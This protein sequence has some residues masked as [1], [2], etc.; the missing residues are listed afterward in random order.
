VSRFTAAGLGLPAPPAFFHPHTGIR[1]SA[2]SLILLVLALLGPPGCTASPDSPIEVFGTPDTP[3]LQQ[4]VAGLRAG[5]AP[6]PLRVTL[7]SPAEAD[8]ADKLRQV[9]GRRPPLLIVL[10]TPALMLTAPAEKNIPVVFAMV[11][12]PYF[13]GAAYDPKRPE[14][15]QRNVTGIASPPP[16][17]AA[18]EQ[19]AKL[20]GRRPWGLIYDPLDGASLEIKEKFES[21]APKFGLM[22]VTEASTEASTDQ[23]ALDNL[24]ARG[25]KVLYLPPTAS[26]G[27]YGPML[28]EMGR[29]RKIMVV[30]SHPELSGNGA[31]LRVVIDYQR[32][33]EETAALAK[34]ILS[35]QEPVQIPIA[36][37]TPLAISADEALL[38][39]WSGYP[40]ANR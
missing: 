10:G 40:P 20:L 39:F 12:N 35:G 23:R 6:R 37:E 5:L 24:L 14:V 33:G 15:H 26:A 19:G 2:L 34:R 25:A 21:L 18:L 22:P 17:A 31:I 36:D 9:R 1:M 13:T 11:A 16:V 29:G 32:L 7:F 8:G 38:N 28:L 4:V 27:R 30:S 3:R